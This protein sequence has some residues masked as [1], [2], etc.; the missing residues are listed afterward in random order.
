VPGNR[1]G[2]G[3]RAPGE[4]LPDPPGE[5]RH[6]FPVRRLVPDS[7]AGTLGFAPGSVPGTLSLRLIEGG[8][9][10]Q[11]ALPLV[12]LPG[13]RELHDDGGAGGQGE[14]APG[15]RRV[16]GRQQHQVAQPSAGG[17]PQVGLASSRMIWPFPRADRTG[18]TA[19][20]RGG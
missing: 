3:G 19:R 13:A 10:D 11:H 1:L 2:V 16:P 5:P 12:A 7:A 6:V 17:A 9:L 8:G 14:R 4:Q 18:R 20:P 15:E